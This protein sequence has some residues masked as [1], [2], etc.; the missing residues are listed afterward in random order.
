MTTRAGANLSASEDAVAE[1]T[2]PPTRNFRR[3][4][5]EAPPPDDPAT[6]FTAAQEA[7]RYGLVQ[8]APAQEAPAELS[9]TV[10]GTPHDRDFDLLRAEVAHLA[11]FQAQLGLRNE[12]V[13]A[14]LGVSF[15]DFDYVYTDTA[16]LS[17]Q[18]PE[19]TAVTIEYAAL[20]RERDNTSKA[21]GTGSGGSS[22]EDE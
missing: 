6:P 14:L 13:R 9:E 7:V 8:D 19:V 3:G 16:A 5:V 1:P 20:S 11:F 12:Q 2:T 17:S 22:D 15:E 18:P 21:G 10:I 4:H